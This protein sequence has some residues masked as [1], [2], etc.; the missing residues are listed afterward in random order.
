MKKRTL[1]FLISSLLLF[2]LQGVWLSAEGE[3]P[4]S[5]KLRDNSER[6]NNDLISLQDTS[7]RYHDNLSLKDSLLLDSI[8]QV[9]RN[10]AKNKYVRFIAEGK[11]PIGFINI[12]YNN[13]FS[14]NLFE[15]IKVGIGAETNRLVSKYASLGGYI[16]YSIKD[17]KI[18]HGSWINIY[19]NGYY[20]FRISFGYRDINMEYGESEFLEKK[21][22]LNP[23]SY[24]SLLIKNMFAT[25]R[26][27]LGVELRPFN[28]LNTYLFSDLS[29]NTSRPVNFFLSQHTFPS[30]RLARLGLQL[31]YSPGIEFIKDPDILIE[32]TIPKSDW[33]LTAIRGMNLLGG[34]FDYTKL[35]FKGRFKFNF[36]QGSNTRII[37]R[38]GF[39]SDHAPIIELFNGYGSY[40]DA[41]SFIAPFSFNTMRQNEFAATQYA[42]IHLR[43]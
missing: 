15:G 12:N 30:T 31:R 28:E 3:F 40:A 43:P 26:Y 10:A 2:F 33:F 22:L 17:D 24:R 36:T 19:P 20:D 5:W 35:E 6:G 13:L 32:K 29:D 18:H 21:S 37:L 41:F 14:Y 4:V 34:D 7:I 8:L 25:K 11:I 16:T 23:E 9:S 27:T 39:I 38:S 42:A 1:Q